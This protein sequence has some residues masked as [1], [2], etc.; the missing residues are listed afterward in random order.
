MNERAVQGR[1]KRPAKKLKIGTNMFAVAK[2][3]KKDLC[4]SSR[5]VLQHRESN[6]DFFCKF[7]PIISDEFNT[8]ERRFLR[9][10]MEG[11]ITPMTELVLDEQWSQQVFKKWT[12]YCIILERSN[13]YQ[14]YSNYLRR[15][16][17]SNLLK[18]AKY[19]QDFHKLKIEQSLSACSTRTQQD[20][21]NTLHE[22][23]KKI[24]GEDFTELVTT[25]SNAL[26]IES[27]AEQG[28]VLPVHP[29]VSNPTLT[30]LV[31]TRNQVQVPNAL[32]KEE[33][34]LLL[35]LCE[36]FFKE[37]PTRKNVNWEW[38]ES[39]WKGTVCE[40]TDENKQI[41]IRAKNHLRES[42]NYWKRSTEPILI[43]EAAA[44]VPDLT[45]ANVQN[46]LPVQVQI[47][48]QNVV[49]IR[50]LRE[51]PVTEDEKAFLKEYG[52]KREWKG[53][54]KD[55]LCSA[56]SQHF[57]HQRESQSLYQ[58]FSYEK[59]KVHKYRNPS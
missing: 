21:V 46:N 36:K 12:T 29:P 56:F 31:A 14:E 55:A 41:F 53:I 50:E 7:G 58:F 17:K 22:A 33:K 38:L 39:A 59:S 43:E 15:K 48:A 45:P 28:D 49:V 52:M 26:Q 35:T 44:N 11:S 57:G 30:Q 13:K 23:G 4:I 42:Y 19:I 8:L 47:P 51:G 5:A 1:S 2:G 25:P 16:T 6:F 3:A 20:I 37:Y 54:K 9:H 32:T 18:Q 10:M 40:N 27:R 34:E 24:F